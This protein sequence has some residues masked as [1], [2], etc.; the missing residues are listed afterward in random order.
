M[1]AAPLSAQVRLEGIVRDDMT[2]APIPDARIELL[3]GWGM[4]RRSRST[5]SLGTFQFPIKRL[6]VYRLRVRR[7]GY[8]ESMG[9]LLTEAYFYLNVEF[10][11]RSNAA[12][13]APLTLLGRAQKLPSP[14]MQGFHAR[15]REGR[16]RY[17]TREDV[18]AVRPGYVSDM[19]A[20][21]PGMIIR[22]SG[23]DQRDRT[24]FARRVTAAGVRQADCALRVY[25]DGEL[26]NPPLPTG[27]NS[28]GGFDGTVEQTMVEGIE[29]YLDP[30]AVPQEFGAGAGGCGAV[31]VW[32]RRSA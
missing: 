11:M 20:P 30:A 9:T 1:I 7:R 12:L 22:R 24:L 4:L 6:G 18:E 32:T 5:D 3:D 21:M 27:E 29:L 14:A 13:L 23:S 31:A 28:P 19:L 17:F 2:G 26:L 25:V 15:M 8:A 10:R 16:G